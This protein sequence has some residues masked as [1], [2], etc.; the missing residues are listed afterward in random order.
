MSNQSRAF[1]R[2][3]MSKLKGGVMAESRSKKS[4]GVPQSHPGGPPPPSLA[5]VIPQ[6]VEV[7]IPRGRRRFTAKFKLDTL[8]KL[9]ACKRDGDVGVFCLSW[10]MTPHRPHAP[11]SQRYGIL[12]P[13]KNQQHKPYGAP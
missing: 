2:E 6:D 13:P 12:G 10:N 11:R 5:G 3:T 4:N 8:K 9:D 1:G 7:V